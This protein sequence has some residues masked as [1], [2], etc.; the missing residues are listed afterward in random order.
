MVDDLHHF[1]E[2]SRFRLVRHG[3]SVSRFRAEYSLPRHNNYI[4]YGVVFSPFLVI[5]LPVPILNFLDPYLVDFHFFSGVMFKKDTS[6]SDCFYLSNLLP[7]ALKKDH[8]RYPFG[9][10]VGGTKSTFNS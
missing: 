10:E 3:A 5:R 9:K 2:R 8:D 4:T 7:K 6:F 1:R